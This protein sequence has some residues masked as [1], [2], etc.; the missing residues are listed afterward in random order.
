[1]TGFQPSKWLRI[2]QTTPFLRKWS[3][4][5]LGDDDLH[6]LEMEIL[7]GPERHPII[8]GSGGV[9]KIRFARSGERRGKSGAYRVCYV[10]FTLHGMVFLLTAFGKSEKSTLTKAEQ[11]AIAAIV[12]DIEQSIDQGDIR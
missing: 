9:R 7:K 6:A 2:I 4:L 10:Y 12:Q 1:M 5:G 11:S 3:R 8:K